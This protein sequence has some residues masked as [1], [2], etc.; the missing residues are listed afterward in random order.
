MLKKFKRNVSNIGKT[1]A[2]DQF[3]NSDFKDIVKET[4]LTQSQNIAK[5]DKLWKLLENY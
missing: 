5:K 2:T 4:F 3:L 1:M